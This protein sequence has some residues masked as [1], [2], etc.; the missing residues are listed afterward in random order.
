ME[1]WR[2]GGESEWE[3]GRVV[4]G[5]ETVEQKESGREGGSEGAKWSEGEGERGRGAR[6][7]WMEG[8]REEGG[9]GATDQRE[10]GR[11]PGCEGAYGSEGES[12]G[13]EG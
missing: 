6:T 7:G 3:G 9:E 8:G 1:G 2:E 12:V 5:G 10:S 11:E 13:E 4:A